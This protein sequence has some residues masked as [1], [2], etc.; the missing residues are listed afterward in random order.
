MINELHLPVGKPAIIHLSSKDVIHS[1]FLPQMRV[2]QDAIPG[3]EVP[4]WFEPKETGEFEIACA[5]LCGLGHYRMRGYLIIHTPEEYEEWL[6]T[7]QEEKE[8]YGW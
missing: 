5:Q 3:I 8:L 1:F 4:I 7:K 2:K 6:K